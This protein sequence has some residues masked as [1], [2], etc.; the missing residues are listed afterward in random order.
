MVMRHRRWV[1]VARSPK[2]HDPGGTIPLR[3]SYGPTSLSAIDVP[4]SDERVRRKA[5][6]GWS[7]ATSPDSSAG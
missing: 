5:G 7:R 4:F 2:G 6:K 3:L 1:D